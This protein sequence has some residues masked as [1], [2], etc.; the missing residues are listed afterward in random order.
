MAN[1]L[2]NS[3]LGNDPGSYLKGEIEEAISPVTERID[4]LEKK[5]DLLNMALGRIEA[6]LTTLQPL[7]KVISKLPFLK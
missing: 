7:S 4:R 6:L 2:I 5:L 3:L 1:P